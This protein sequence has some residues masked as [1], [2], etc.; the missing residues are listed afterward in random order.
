[1]PTDAQLG[2]IADYIYNTNGI[3]T[4]YKAATRSDDKAAE[5]GFTVTFGSGFY[6]WAGVE[7]D[8]YIAYGRDFSP[9]GTDRYGNT[10]DDSNRQAVCLGD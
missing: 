1:M 5:L 2:E 8:N 3:G 7:D 9:T 4:G 6:V 10:R